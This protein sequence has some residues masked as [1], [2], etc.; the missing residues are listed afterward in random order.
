MLQDRLQ[1]LPSEIHSPARRKLPEREQFTSLTV[2]ARSSSK[3]T[4]AVTTLGQT[5]YK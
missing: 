4:F 2:S 5:R 1:G 3:P